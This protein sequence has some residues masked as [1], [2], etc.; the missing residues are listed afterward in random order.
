MSFLRNLFGPSQE[1][2][3]QQLATEIDAKFVDGGMWKGDKV[4][5]Q[6]KQWTI[7]LDTYIVSTGK[8][9]MTFTRLRAPYVNADGFRFKVSRKSMFSGLGKV[10]GMQDVEIGEPQFD[11]AFIVQGNDEAKLK[12]LFANPTIRQLLSAQPDV[13]FAVND[14]EGWFATQ[15]PEGVDE[16]TFTA[17]GVITEVE[18]LKQLY[19][20]F[21]TVLNHLCQIGSAYENDP[22][23][24]L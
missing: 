7:T 12:Q 18:R 15:F 21:A 10:F 4:Q 1:E 3:W 16:L 23:V 11:E 14:D 6:V 19:E 9:W 8:T 2:I 17:Y 22:Q 13:N 20:L 5:A 24:T